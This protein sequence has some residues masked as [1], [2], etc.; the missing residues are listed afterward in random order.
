MG[1]CTLYSLIF[2]PPNIYL[3]CGSYVCQNVL[4]YGIMGKKMKPQLSILVPSGSF[5]KDPLLSP[6]LFSISGEVIC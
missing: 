5:A 6:S 3:L 4:I 1:F 2:F